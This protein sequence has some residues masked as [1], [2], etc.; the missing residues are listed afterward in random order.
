[1]PRLK[2]AETA[3]QVT[4]GSDAVTSCAQPMSRRNSHWIRVGSKTSAASGTR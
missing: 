3:I 1:M 4:N 2:A